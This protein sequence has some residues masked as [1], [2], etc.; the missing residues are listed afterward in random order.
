[1]CRLSRT[2]G[3]D[4]RCYCT[5]TRAQEMNR[6]WCRRLGVWEEEAEAAKEE[7]RSLH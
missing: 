5:G 3:A 7:L 1:M 2:F 6:W 4:A